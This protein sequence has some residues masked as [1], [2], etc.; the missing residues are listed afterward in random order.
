MLK[1]WTNAKQGVIQT[2]ILDNLNL[3]AIGG[4]KVYPVTSA[5]PPLNNG[6]VLLACGGKAN[7]S[8]K[9]MGII[10]KNKGV[11][12]LRGVAIP[13]HGG[14]AQMLTTYDPSILNIDPSKSSVIGWDCKLVDRLIRTGTLEPEIGDYEYVTNF[15]EYVAWVTNEYNL[16]GK[17][18]P[19][20]LDL[21]TIG[22][23]P[24]AKDVYIVSITISV[25]EGYSNVVR[26][27]SKTVQPAYRLNSKLVVKNKEF[28]DQ[29]RFFLNSPMVRLRGANLKFDFMWLTYH[30]GLAKAEAFSM[31]TTVVGGLL[32]ENRSNS[33][34]NHAKELTSMG[35]YDSNLNKKYNKSRMDLVPPEEL[36]PYAGGD[37]DACLRVSNVMVRSLAKQP[38]LQKFY[39]KILHPALRAVSKMERRGIMVDAPEYDRL[40]EEVSIEVAR[41]HKQAL[42]ML[43]A[44]IRNKYKDDLK[45]TRGCILREF[46]FTPAGMNLKPLMFTDK[47][48]E[49][50]TALEHL[51]MLAVQ[52]N[53][54]V[55]FVQL[56]SEYGSAKKTLS[57]YIV[58]FKKH[59]RSDGKFHPTYMLHRGDYA[60]DE[61]GTVSGRSS[62]KDPAFQTI[63]KHTKWTKALRRVY[64]APE[65]HAIMV[66]DFSQG[67][68]RIAACLANEPTMIAAYKKGI[69]IHAVTASVLCNMTFEQFMAQPEEWRDD[70]R[71]GGKAGNFGLLYGMGANGFQEYARKTYGVYLTMGE[72]QAFRSGFFSKYKQLVTWHESCRATAHRDLQ[73]SSPLG[74]V[75]HLPNINCKERDLVARQERQ[76]INFGPQ[77]VLSDLGLYA[78]GQLD[79][80]YPNLWMWG[81]THDAIAF[82]VPI[83]EVPLWYPRIKDVMENLPYT[84]ELGWKPQLQFLVDGEMSLTNWSEVKKYKGG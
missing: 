39:T 46:L 16:D 73:I 21:E 44:R 20:T 77:S 27:N 80:I 45:L 66:F 26:Y 50:S 53:E 76:G 40:H 63:P 68:L 59:L 56:M 51:E 18:I 38:K 17:K 22:L 24:Y 67:E 31:D 10:P 29:V 83:D 3:A 25:Q 15:S 35:G 8:L 84:S 32:D 55:P 61:S 58:G 47:Q 78:M 81:F 2:A 69:D 62:A 19:V 64:I 36:L 7:D 6:D 65:G 1:I 70:M 48:Q 42:G 34:E 12:A 60:G 23:D 82:Y 75:R 9:A 11:E 33:L 74:R 4:Y 57:T 54:L 79:R 37:T 5:L 30:W 41:V 28:L 52:H 14:K 71:S 72:A 13:L 43:P 49:P